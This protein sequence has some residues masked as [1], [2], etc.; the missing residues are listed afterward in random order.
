MVPAFSRCPL[1]FGIVSLC[2]PSNPL[3]I[4]GVLAA[5][6]LEIGRATLLMDVERPPQGRD[7]L[8][9]LAH[10]LG[11]EAEGADH[12]RHIHLVGP[13]NWCVKGSCP[14]PQEPGP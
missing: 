1:S 11:V 13:S 5:D 3:A 12:L 2:A 14:G 8:G 6:E 9:W 4:D 7:D 10:P